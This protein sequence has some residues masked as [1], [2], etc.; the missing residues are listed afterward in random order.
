VYS[1][2]VQQSEF[3]PVAY[4]NLVV[5]LA[6]I[7]PDDVFADS[8]SPGDFAIFQSLGSQ[9]DDSQLASARFPRSVSI[10]QPL[11]TWQSL[12]PRGGFK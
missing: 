10:H 11:L 6:E 5:D 8:E 4:S 12:S 2:L 7:I 9:L 1:G 3:D